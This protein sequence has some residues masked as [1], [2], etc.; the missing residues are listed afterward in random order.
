HHLGRRR[1]RAR[2]TRPWNEILEPRLLLS[3]PDSTDGYAT[4]Q[5]TDL[6]QPPRQPGP[7]LALPPAL[8]AASGAPVGPGGS[9][10]A[11][12]PP[13]GGSGWG[14]TSLISGHSSITY[15]LGLI[16]KTY[17]TTGYFTAAAAGSSIYYDFSTDATGSSSSE[18]DLYFYSY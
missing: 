10:S 13:S 3:S 1:R 5:F 9:N 14:P 16:D 15:Q 2:F 4:P 11:G 6:V 18:I 7:D 17:Q 12:A 8:Q